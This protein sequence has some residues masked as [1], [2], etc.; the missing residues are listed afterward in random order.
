MNVLIAGGAGFIG[1][2]LAEL[3]LRQGGHVVI[4]DT[5]RVPSAARRHFDALPGSWTEAHGSVTD[6]EAVVSILSE[7]RISY[8]FYGAAITSGPQR[9]RDS[10]ESV[11]SINLLGLA[12]MAKSAAKTGIQRLLNISSGAAYGLP[13]E[14]GSYVLHEARTR[15]QPA[16]L[17]SL[18]KLA[19]EVTL[20]RIAEL[21]GLDA[22]SVRLS[23]I[24]G[25]WE[26]DT[27]FRDTLSAPMQASVAAQRGE[28][29][30][31]SRRECRDWTYSRH[32]AEAL[33]LLIQF[34]RPR[35]DL[36]NI[37][38]GRTWSTADWCDRLRNRFPAFRYRFA[39]SGETA[40]VDLYTA[41]DRLP[42]DPGRLQDDTCHHLPDDIDVMFADFETWLDQYPDFWSDEPAG[43][44]PSRSSPRPAG[45]QSA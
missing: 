23:S 24:F 45:R 2:N 20:R 40:N 15:E 35:Y 4:Y 22:L 32:V 25:P 3:I 5:G 29:V 10:P 11:L 6:E 17:Y 38:S 30:I 9:E 12:T 34:Q 8:V 33:V 42:L 27:G 1:L 28:R 7:Q 44:S 39:D 31:L 18:S 43:A 16:T 13:A 21:T 14:D 41:T 26:R 36:Y 19:S 37:S